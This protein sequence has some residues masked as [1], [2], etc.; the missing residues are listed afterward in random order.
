MDYLYIKAIHIIFVVTWFAGLFYMPRLFIYN[1]EANEKDAATQAILHTQFE[2]MMKRLWYGI[3]WPSAILTLILGLTV[4]FKG[5]WYGMLFNDAGKWLLIKLIFVVLLYAYHFSIQIVLNQELKGIYKF[6]S[7]QLRMYNEIATI[8]LVAIVILATV[9]QTMSFIWGIG[10]IVIFIFILMAA[11]KI[12]KLI[13]GKK[14]T[15]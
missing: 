10:G 6:S 2:I 8:F 4:L 3:T 12:Y 15:K 7:Q 9:K 5:G 11:I 13:R 14:E 1:T